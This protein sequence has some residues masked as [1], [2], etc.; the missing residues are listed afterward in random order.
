[1]EKFVIQGQR[2]LSGTIEAYGAKNA[3][4]PL[5]AATILTKEDCIISNLPLIEDVFRTIEL[6][7]SMGAKVE[8]IGKRKVLVNTRALDPRKINK[9]LM[10]RFRG[11]ILFFGPLLARFHKVTLPQPGGCLIGARPIDTHL[12]AFSQLG[13]NITKKGKLYTLKFVGEVREQVVL[14]EFSV[15][16]TQNMLLFA[17]G[18]GKT[19]VV[20]I[21]DQDYQMQELSRVLGKM[22]AT[23]SL[24]GPHAVKV[25][26]KRSLKGFKH[27][28]MYD[29]IEA[30][31]FILLAIV[32]K[33]DILVK[34]VEVKFLELFLKKLKD[35]GAKFD[36]L[37]KTRTLADIHIAGN[38]SMVIDK[39]QS[40]IYPGIHSD[41]QSPLGVLATQTRGSTLLHDPLYE[42]RL[43]YLEELTKMGAEVYLTDPH[44]AIINGPTKLRGTDLGSFDLRG[45]AALI[46]AALI[47]KGQS[48]ISNIYQVD[49][50]YEKIEER[51]Q[52]LGADIKRVTS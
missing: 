40:F 22:G 7:Q 9:D 25:L 26:G 19:V 14:N 34:N 45:G 13:V 38:Q 2:P 27:A 4:F 24:V 49:R 42:G 51:L 17:A 5:L 29:P 32:S 31:T 36:I 21:A 46:I 41:L 44:R 11:A 3:A 12:D 16:A 8:W 18:I 23:V 15:T 52:K 10:L 1:M 30:G 35:F 37:P 50:G 20:K 48:T 28:L 33:G 43:K 39:V 6:L 47:A